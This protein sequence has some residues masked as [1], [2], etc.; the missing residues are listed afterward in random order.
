MKRFAAIAIIVFIASSVRADVK[1]AGIFG[2][3]MVVQR[4]MKIPIWGA[5]DPGEKISVKVLQQEQ[6]A[7][8]DD[9]GKWRVTLDPIDSKEPISITV[10]GKNSITLNDVLVGEVWVCSGQSNMERR[11]DQVADAKETIASADHPQIRLFIVQH[12]ND[13][14]PQDDVKGGKWMIC[15]PETIPHFTAVGYAFG[16][17]LQQKLNVPMGLIESNWGGTRAEAWMTKQAFDRLNLPYEPAWTEESVHPKQD[18]A[19]TKPTPARPFEAPAVLYNGMIHPLAGLAMRGV[20]WYQGESNAE[21]AEKY[22]DVLGAMIKSWREAWGE[23]DFPFLVVQLANYK[24]NGKWA[25]VREAQAAMTTQLPNVGLAVT[26]DI[27]ESN[28]I[29]PMNKAEVGRRL[30]LS[31]EKIAYGQDIVYSG[32][33]IKSIRIDGDKAILTFDNIGGGLKVKGDKLEGFEVAG[34]DNN[35][36]S[37]DAKIDGDKVIVTSDAVKS[38]KVVRYGWADDPRCTLYNDADLPAVPFRT[39]R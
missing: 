15:S 11:V 36:V 22:A 26:I 7:T 14:Q 16:L 20:I 27:G 24:S 19:S 39:A 25:D 30:A 13:D 29:H 1:I 31:A 34:E 32:P 8:A 2:D 17:D 21:H 37:A 9:K 3:H 5:A 33:T 38:P 6:T 28:N 35:F 12:A 18:P 10:A 4:G 23:G